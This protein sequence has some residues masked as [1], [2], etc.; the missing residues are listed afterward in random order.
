MFLALLLGVILLGYLYVKKKFNYFASI[1]IP[2]QPGTF[3]LGSDLVW[4]M[5]QGKVSFV[6]IHEIIY[7]EFPEAKVAGYYAAFG[8]PVFVIRDMD[9]VKRIMIK[10][11]EHFM[12]RRVM[13]L[14]PKGNKYL[15]K[16]LSAMRGEFMN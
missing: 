3:P 1:G 2:H 16:M 8:D 11:F 14:N 4:K 5:F 13:E 15:L 9:L 12:D 6:Q 10:D 7:K